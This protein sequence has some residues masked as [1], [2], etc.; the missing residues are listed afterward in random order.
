MV[1]LDTQKGKNATA[2]LMASEE[3]I[4]RIGSSELACEGIYKI[5][6]NKALQSDLLEVN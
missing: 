5:N 6:I 3:A 2:L 4:G 1:F